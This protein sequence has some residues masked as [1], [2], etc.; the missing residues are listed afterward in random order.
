MRLPEA[1]TSY[2]KGKLSNMYTL[3]NFSALL[4]QAKNEGIITS[5]ELDVLLLWR[6]NPENY[7]DKI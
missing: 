7:Y 2:E 6:K 3:S 4:L 1:N 5:E